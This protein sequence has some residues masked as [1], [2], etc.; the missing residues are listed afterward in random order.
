MLFID[1][2]AI[3]EE[4]SL[5]EVA[6]V[7]EMIIQKLAEIERSENIKI[8]HAVESGSRAWGF[9]SPDSD[10]DVRFIYVRNPEFYLKLEKTRDVI[11]MPIND[12][13]DINGWDLNKALRLLHGSNP[14]LFEWMSSPVVYRQTEFIDQLRPIMDDYFSCKSGLY[15]YLSMA[16]GNYRDYLK[17]D[18][19]RAKKYFYVLRPI[20]ACKWILRTHTKPPMLF[21]ELADV[22]LDD[23]LKP[24]VEKL[25][26]LKMNVPEIKEIP[27]VDEINAYLDRTIAEL[28]AEIAAF[29][30]EHR[31]DWAPLNK[32]FLETMASNIQPLTDDEKIDLVAKDILR[33]FK[34]AF[35]KLAE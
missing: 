4:K 11:E 12:M 14:T 35:K 34:P 28:K 6:I 3:I 33:R 13:L 21:S 17:G 20:L 7:K 1:T 10:Y 2:R 9:P 8:L 15:H 22:E 18:M 31:A 27:R 5:E 26:D 29:P 25:L 32:L 23:A 30:A 16:E 24:A 19:V